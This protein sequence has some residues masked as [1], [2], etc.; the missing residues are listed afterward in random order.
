MLHRIFT[1]P[2]LAAL[3]IVAAALITVS[4]GGSSTPT[5]LVSFSVS[6]APVGDLEAV[7]ITIDRVI[8]NQPGDDI[9][10]DEF[11]NEDP[12]GDPTDTITIDLLDYQ[13]LDKLLIVDGIELKVGDYQNLRLSIVEGIDD[14]YVVEEGGAVKLIK[15]PSGELK[16]G[17]F[18]VEN[19]GVQA[20]VIEFNLETSMTYNPGP[21]RYILK[22]RGVRIVDVET[23]ALLDGTVDP[24]LFDGESPCDEKAAPELGNVVYLYRGHGLDADALGD[25]FDPELDEDAAATLAAPFAAERAASDGAYSFSYLPAGDYTLAFSC[26]AEEDDPE[27]DD[28]IVIPTPSG[29]LREVS[30]EP[31][32]ALTCDF[33]VASGDCF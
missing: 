5:T 29:E 2:L 32:E 20:F 10:I 27:Y 4:C 33:P 3:S 31:A 28:G 13:G 30:L 15:Q 19:V 21:D 22:P 7:V 14:S 12:A 16:L 18:E 8:V 1:H 24:A 6:D 26:D 25:L 11:P 23:A 17:K 9:V